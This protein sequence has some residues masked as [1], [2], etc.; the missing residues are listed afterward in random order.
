MAENV[1]YA[2]FQPQIA[3]PVEP[4]RPRWSIPAAIGVWLFSVGTLLIIPIVAVILWFILLL[5]MGKPVPSLTEET[6]LLQW[7][8]SPP[9]I[10]VQ[11]LSTMVAHLLTLGFIWMV[12]TGMGKRPFLESLDWY[13]NGRSTASKM[14]YIGGI[15]ASVIAILFILGS[16]LP[17]DKETAFDILL[18]TSRGVRYAVAF[19]AVFTAPITEEAVYRGVLFT[20]LRGRIGVNTTIVIISLLFVGVHVPQYWGAWAGLIGLT[21][22][23][24]TLTIIRARTE[25]LLPCVGVHM[26]F[27][28]INAVLLIF[29]R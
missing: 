22:L 2:G 4:N 27:N 12:V 25:S 20:G 28:S 14:L 1:D 21:I 9:V 19:L 10:L 24:F 23:S 17:P 18:K 5:F 7:V 11:V 15:V 29:Q 26:L 6:A 13:W 16:I 3:P 8:S